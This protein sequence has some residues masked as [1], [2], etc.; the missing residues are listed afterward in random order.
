MISL[1]WTSGRF[2]KLN[3]IVYVICRKIIG[4][5][6]RALMYAVNGFTLFIPGN[7]NGIS[8]TDWAVRFLCC[9]TLLQIGAGGGGREGISGRNSIKD[10]GVSC[11]QKKLR[12]GPAFIV[13]EQGLHS[14][15]PR[16]PDSKDGHILPS[17]LKT[18]KALG[19]NRPERREYSI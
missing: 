11:K 17:T 2:I 1:R 3:T 19:T 16:G 13:H 8:A 18:T 7:Q 12:Q 14:K 5:N 4:V 9:C 10:E 15:A 6:R